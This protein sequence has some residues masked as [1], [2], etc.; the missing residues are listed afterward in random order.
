MIGTQLSP[1][2]RF[3][4]I[5][6]ATDGSEFAAGATRVALEIAKH[7][8][9]RLIAMTMVLSNME[10]D[11]LAP[12]AAQQAEAAAKDILDQV[13]AAAAQEGVDCEPLIRHGDDP[14]REIIEAAEEMDID[15]VVMGRRGR[16]GLAR[17][18]VGDATA[19]VAGQAPCS[20]LVVP[21]AAQMPS[22]GILVATDGS[23]Y[24]DAAGATAYML[25][26]KCGLPVTVV[27]VTKPIHHE[28]RRAEAQQAVDRVVGLLRQD[29]I[30]ADGLVVEGY[31]DQE[32]VAAA[33]NRGADLIVVGSHG[34]TGFLD[35][36]LIGSVS[37][38]V[39][40]AAQCAVLVAR[41]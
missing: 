34:R 2:G 15:V 33:E 30:T 26:E 27:S 18:M 21:R 16:R 7:C 23:R 40:G 39:I 38:R 29:G 3:D 17:L 20:V 14:A 4:K 11:A 9:S 1:I 13:A 22:K 24:S 19:K 37:E 31:P 12:G 5:M 35:R 25:A 10:Y 28:A 36:I 8:E 32:I 41:A 6:L